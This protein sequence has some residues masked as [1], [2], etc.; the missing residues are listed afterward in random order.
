[1]N[2]HWRPTPRLRFVERPASLDAENARTIKIL[3][4]WHGPEL[5]AY[6]RDDTTGEWRDVPL[7]EGE[8]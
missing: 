5:P 1:M 2:Q 6:M 3:Q 4:Q 8:P 7:I